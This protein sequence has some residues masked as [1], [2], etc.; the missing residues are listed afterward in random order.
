MKKLQRKK[1]HQKKRLTTNK[2]DV[3]QPFIEHLYELRRR[4]IYVVASIIIFS[5]LAYFVQ[6]YLVSF[7]LHPSKGQ[8]FIYTSP[9]G[10]IGFLFSVCTY[11]GIA[12]SIPVIVYQILGFLEPLI[13]E[14]IRRRIIKYSLVSA[15]LAVV[16]FCFGYFIGLPIALHFLRNQFTDRQIRPLFTIQEYMS[17]LMVYLLGSSLLCQLPLFLMFTNHIRPLKPRK[18]FNAQRYVIVAAFVIAMIMAPTTNIF[19]QLVI[20]GPIIL[21]YNLSIILIWRVNRQ[22]RRPD[23]V[24]KLLEKD[25]EVQAARF[26]HPV[27]ELATDQAGFVNKPVTVS[28]LRFNSNSKRFM[29][30]SRR[31]P[32]AGVNSPI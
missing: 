27:L 23:Y 3:A 25:R 6:Q 10:G 30:V 4:L 21:V 15:A 14:H 24:A 12:A 22:N 8:Q 2:S 26:H 32:S 9:G 17:F 5:T 19:D 29:D 28:G 16:G 13:A 31:F 18:L 11:V 1:N 7:L 20:A